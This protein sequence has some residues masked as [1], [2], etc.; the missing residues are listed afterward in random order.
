MKPVKVKI[1]VEGGGDKE[2]TKL[3]RACRR[4]FGKFFAKAG[5]AERMP[6]VIACGDRRQTYDKFCIAI[7]QRSGD[8][9]VLLV[10]SEEAVIADTPWAH[11][12]NRKDDGWERP[13]GADDGNAHLMV[14]VMES[15]F[16]A[17][18]D[19][20]AAYFGDGFNP[21][22]LP[23]P[24]QNLEDVAKEDVEKALENSTR[25]CRKKGRYDKGKHSF[26]L[27]EKLD[28]KSVVDASPHARRLVE[29][30]AAKMG[31]AVP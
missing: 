9:P 8:F 31:V 16:L 13:S 23:S 5:F 29:T 3:R 26:E 2:N 22:A 30:I 20:L 6:K 18:R 28:A 4:S 14:Q 10:D 27:L 24:Q 12:R 19:Y 21:N 25:Q 11:L 1:Y 17:D 7:A 15:W